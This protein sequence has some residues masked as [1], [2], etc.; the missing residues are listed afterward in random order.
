MNERLHYIHGI[1]GGVGSPVES[2]WSVVKCRDP[3]FVL[4][5]SPSWY[6]GTMRVRPAD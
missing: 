2:G 3:V 4:A 6:A 5:R 1:R